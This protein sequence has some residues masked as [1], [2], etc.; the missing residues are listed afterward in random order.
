MFAAARARP[1]SRVARGALPAGEPARE[2]AAK[3]VRGARR[4][5]NRHRDRWA[6]S[7]RR[8]PRDALED[9][10]GTLRDVCV[11]FCSPKT[12]SNVG[13]M[14]RA[15]AAFSRQY[16]L[17]ILSNLRYAMTKAFSA[18]GKLLRASRHA[19]QLL[20]S[21][22]RNAS[23]RCAGLSR[24]SSSFISHAHRCA[25]RQNQRID[26]PQ[27]T[28]SSSIFATLGSVMHASKAFACA[29]IYISRV[30]SFSSRGRFLEDVSFI[31]LS[32]APL[33]SSPHNRKRSWKNCIISTLVGRLNAT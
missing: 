3:R 28:E 8:G 23:N 5:D 30:S 12:A 26:R 2:G 7:L 31:N 14:A 24:G 33:K 4:G 29:L 32:E 16:C 25:T 18:G 19:L 15:C 27:L 22:A 21:W 9:P 1:A 13:A 11:I 6:A 20:G 10:P 17:P